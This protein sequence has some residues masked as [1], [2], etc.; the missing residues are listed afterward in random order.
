MKTQELFGFPPPKGYEWA[1]E[2]RWGGFAP[3]TRL[4]PWY[5]LEEDNMFF[6]N[7]RWPN[8]PVIIDLLAFARR[9]D[10]DEIACFDTSTTDNV[11]LINGW[12]PDGYE[13]LQVYSSFWEWMKSV[14]DDVA[15]WV[16]AS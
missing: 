13:I 14:V 7:N 12:A 11:V 9:Q 16:E 8:K 5:F 4:Q 1:I 6:V 15:D 10:N 2:Q 3:F